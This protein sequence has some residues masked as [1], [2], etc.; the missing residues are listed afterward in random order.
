MAATN[1]VAVLV[2]FERRFIGLEP[3]R[4][5]VKS[6]SDIL[7][8]D[9]AAPRPERGGLGIE[10]AAE[11]MAVAPSLAQ[12]TASTTLANS[13]SMPSPVVLTT[14]PRRTKSEFLRC[15]ETVMAESGRKPIEIHKLPPGRSCFHT[16][17]VGLSRWL[18]VEGGRD[19]D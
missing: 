18:E 16:A 14:R 13:T 1:V 12:C 2:A 9:D 5:S 6:P 15:A 8:V 7:D 4:L 10:P 17:W 3:Y 11:G 19:L